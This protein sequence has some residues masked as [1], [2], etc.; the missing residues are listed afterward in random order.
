[1]KPSV[2]GSAPSTS[3]KATATPASPESAVIPPPRSAPAATEGA[4]APAQA[5]GPISPAGVGR[6]PSQPVYASNRRT[7]A[8][9]PR[10][11]PTASSGP[12]PGTAGTT[13][14]CVPPVW[15]QWAAKKL[16]SSEPSEPRKER[17][18]GPP[19]GPAPAIRSGNG[20]PLTLPI[21]T[22]TPP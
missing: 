10:S 16:C 13:A 15:P 17:T 22:V 1:M 14:T 9:S 3:W 19:P 7:R 11:N 6:E 2:D 4:P 8:P 12:P 21:A 20:S 18:C 5:R